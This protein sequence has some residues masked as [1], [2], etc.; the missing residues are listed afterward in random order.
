MSEVRQVEPMTEY[1]EFSSGRSQENYFERDLPF[2][3]DG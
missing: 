3:R 2:R 1:L